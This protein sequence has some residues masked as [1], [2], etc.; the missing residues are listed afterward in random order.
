[1]FNSLHSN[2]SE[3]YFAP[4]F[5]GFFKVAKQFFYALICALEFKD[6]PMQFPPGDHLLIS[7]SNSSS[8]LICNF[9]SIIWLA[10]LMK[11]SF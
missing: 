6:Y 10:K 1:M 11:S 3:V 5:H 7:Q 9:T 4:N 2:K 8:H